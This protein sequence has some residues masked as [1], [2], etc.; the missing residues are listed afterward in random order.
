LII[1][2]KAAYV[3]IFECI[4]GHL[5]DNTFCENLN[6]DLTEDNFEEYLADGHSDPNLLAELLLSVLSTLQGNGEIFESVSEKTLNAIVNQLLASLEKAKSSLSK[7]GIELR[8]RLALV[9]FGCILSGMETVFEVLEPYA[10]VDDV[11]IK[12]L[13]THFINILYFG[14]AGYIYYRPS[15]NDDASDSEDG[16]SD[17]EGSNSEAGEE[18]RDSENEDEDNDSEVNDSEEGNDSEANDSEEDNSSESRSSSTKSVTY[19]RRIDKSNIEKLC[20]R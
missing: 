18:D 5:R 9:Q 1:G 15:Y 10:C 12:Y 16:D 19:T 4:A 17:K 13:T 2:P 20:R 7:I 11:V 6:D 14:G 3:K 8:R